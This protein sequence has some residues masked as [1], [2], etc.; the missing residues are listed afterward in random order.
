MKILKNKLFKNY[1]SILIPLFIIEILFRLLLKMSIFDWAVFRI[2]IGCN[3]I[4]LLVSFIEQFLSDKINNIISGIVLLIATIYAIMQ[5]GFENYLGVYVSLGT[6]SQLGAVK[7]YIK[8]YFDSFNPL[9]YTM[10]VPFILYIIYKIFGEKKIFK[11]YY[12]EKNTKFAK[13]R[14]KKSI[15]VSLILISITSLVYY[16]SLTANFMQNNLQM[17]S[18]YALFKNPENPNISVNQFGISTFGLLDVK[19]TLIKPD[20]EEFILEEKKEITSEDITDYTRI[21][22][23]TAWL[24]LNEEETNGI[25][26]TLN[27]YFMSQDIPD[28]NEYT[29]LFKDK[30]LI[31][32]MMESVNEIFLHPEYYPTFNKIYNDG[33]SF[34][35]S[36]S[37]RNS[38]STGNNE[39]SGMISLFSIYRTCTANNYKNNE[40]YESI[41]NLFNKKGYETSSYHN[42]TEKY[43]YRS[44]IH[45]NMGSKFYGVTDLGIDYNEAYEEW[46]SDVLLM[47]KAMEHI[48]TT[49]PFMSWITTVTSHQPYYASSEFGD[50]YTGIFDPNYPT[51]L[52][53]YM[54]KLKELD[55]ALNRLLE[56]LKEKNVLDDTVIVLYGDHYPYGLN[57]NDI[58]KA[59]SYD[60]N[61]YNNV[62]KTPF[63]IYNKNLEAKSFDQYTSYM[64]ILPTIANLFDLEYDPRLY[65]GEDILSNEYI[66][67]YKNRVILADGS[68]ENDKAIYNA[69]SGKITYKDTDT[70]TNEEIMKYNKEISNKIKMSNQAIEN[71]YFK[72]L[73]D[74]LKKYEE[75]VLITEN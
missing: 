1:I 40:Y 64:N 49:K 11:N 25:Y 16:I 29:G 54:S 66:N 60:V 71:N 6:S 43:Y 30:N 37:P 36:Y 44:T 8:D 58:N 9:F 5:A 4:S 73:N 22:D 27:N 39:M 59:L 23:D 61:V 12:K 31:V 13:R 7:E 56:L 21:I 32:I 51:N 33:W 65:V 24:K 75:D 14:S 18:T 53:R 50:K 74:G 35:N 52:K 15:L 47:E 17:E 41:F 70:Y 45:K 10:L 42:Y 67:S 62:D 34:K 2:F 20:E 63:V 55:N 19:T 68:W 26:K 28:K 72:Y 46:P 38:C 48:D 57:N 3:I 69:T